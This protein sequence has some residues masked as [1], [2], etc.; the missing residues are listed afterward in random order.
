MGGGRVVHSRFLSGALLGNRAELDDPQFWVK[1]IFTL[2][3]SFPR[4]YKARELVSTI[5]S[6]HWDGRGW[7]GGVRSPPFFRVGGY[8]PHPFEDALLITIS[9]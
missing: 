7:E 1:T 9:L 2:L 3:S 6:S 5:R 4:F 8:P